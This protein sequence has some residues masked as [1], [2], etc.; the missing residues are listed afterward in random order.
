MIS[1]LESSYTLSENTEDIASFS[2]SDPENNSI[3]VG[4][5]GD[6]S[7]NFIVVDNV[8]KYSGG[9]NFENP[10]DSNADNVY[11]LEVFADDGFNRTTQN[12]QLTITNVDEGP[13]FN[14]TEEISIEENVR[15]I[16]AI[17]IND[18]ENDSFTWSI[19][20]GDDSGIMSLV[21]VSGG[22]GNLRFNS[23]TG[24]DYENPSDADTDNV[25]LVQLTA[26]EDKANGL[27][28][29][30]DLRI[31]INDIK[32]TWSI[33]GTLF[34][35][36]LTAID[37][38]VPDIIY[39]P[40][41]LN[42]DIDSAQVILNP[43]DVIGHIGDNSIEV[44]NIGDDGFC[45]EDPDNPGFCDYVEVFNEDPV[46]W[47][48]I[49]GAP[50]LLLTLSIEGLIFEQNGSFYCCTTDGLNADL[51]IY[52]ENGDLADFTYT[53]NSTDTFRQIVLPESG[54]FYAVIRAVTGHTKYVLTLGSNV[55][56][57]L[58]HI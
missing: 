52:D 56:L 44:L 33:S 10:T 6:D 4:V 5:S 34:S 46:D 25:Y 7:T 50:N 11:E 48:K 31:T 40:P 37:G 1:G 38:D 43:T 47:Y 27:S 26:T 18:P 51:F 20:G 2:V 9:L 42:N 53:S 55:T 23:F 21:N 45:I 19:T 16:A 24:V 13:E 36:P 28:T 35:N 57:S 22:V 17:S 8:L 3:T 32:D 58:I 41:T 30:L 54:T 49:S 15:L 29:V 12:V 39:Y 14:I